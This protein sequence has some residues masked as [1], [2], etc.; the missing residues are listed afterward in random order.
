[1][2]DF[3]NILNEYLNTQKAFVQNPKR[4]AEVNAATEMA[5]RL[6][7]KAKIELED[8]PLQMGAII[9]TIEDCFITVREIKKFIELVSKASNF[10]IINTCEDVKLSILFDNALIKI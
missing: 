1:M 2:N 4:I 8:D 6:F 10:E 7:P 3:I 5:C 9:L